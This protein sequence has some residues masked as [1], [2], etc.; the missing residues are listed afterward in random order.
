MLEYNLDWTCRFSFAGSLVKGCNHVGLF[1]TLLIKVPSIGHGLVI[2]LALLI[3]VW[4]WHKHCRHY[5][6]Q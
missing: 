1:L 4:S 6:A 5:L 3:L 2:P